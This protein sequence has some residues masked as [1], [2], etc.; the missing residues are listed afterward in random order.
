MRGKLAKQKFTVSSTLPL[1]VFGRLFHDYDGCSPE[2]TKKISF[3]GCPL[4]PFIFTTKTETIVGLSLSSIGKS[5]MVFLSDRKSS[6]MF[7]L[8]I[9]QDDQ[10]YICTWLVERGTIVTL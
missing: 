8:G 10:R 5:G 9:H 7:G 3:S 2:F 6:Q 1:L 4:A